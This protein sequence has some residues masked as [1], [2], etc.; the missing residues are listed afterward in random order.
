MIP[1]RAYPMVLIAGLCLA[2]TASA[3]SPTAPD[4]ARVAPATAAPADSV[5]SGPRVESTAT[6]IRRL[7]VTDD[8]NLLQRR[9]P[10]NVG[11]P[12]ALM[13]VGG[14]A[15]VLGAVVGGDVGTLFMI[16]GTVTLLIGLYQYLM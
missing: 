1:T 5:A 2:A 7:A 10:Q 3:Q 12:M 6:G 9:Q 4:S 11:K 8:A 14:A 13:I 15:I 16:G